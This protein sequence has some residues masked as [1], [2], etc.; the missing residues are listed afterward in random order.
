MEL[1][2]TWG[3]IAFKTSGSEWDEVVH[4]DDKNTIEIKQFIG[5]VVY[6]FDIKD[7][8]LSVLYKD[9]KIRI[10]PEIFVQ[11]PEPRFKIGDHVIQNNMPARN[12]IIR[13]IT[14]H[15]NSNTHCYYVEYNGK[16]KSTRYFSED[17]TA[18]R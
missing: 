14:W 1:M 7:G 3:V 18:I 9:T 16:N 11:V 4:R 2:K 8:Y 15:Y 10:L 6:C 13:E 17:L 5:K 12:Y